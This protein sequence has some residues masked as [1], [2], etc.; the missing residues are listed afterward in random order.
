[1]E[2]A[3]KTQNNLGQVVGEVGFAQ[4]HKDPVTVSLSGY[5][6]ASLHHTPCLLPD[7]QNVIFTFTGEVVVEGTEVSPQ[8]GR[9]K[10][11]IHQFA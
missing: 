2:E 5:V 8:A 10:T 7:I 9:E 11:H 6:S 4:G 1:M 3:G